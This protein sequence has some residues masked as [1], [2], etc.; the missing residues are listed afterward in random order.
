MGLPIL[1][2][3]RGSHETFP[4]Y[5]SV[6]SFQRMSSCRVEGGNFKKWRPRKKWDH[7]FAVLHY[8]DGG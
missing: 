4:I 2:D 3:Q 1:F 8:R 6:V 5:E 7:H